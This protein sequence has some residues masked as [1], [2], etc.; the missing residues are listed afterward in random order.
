MDVNTLIPLISGALAAAGA[1]YLH[2]QRTNTERSQL[3]SEQY[4][5]ASKMVEQYVDDL[6]ELSERVGKLQLGL[7]QANEEL[8]TL[9]AENSRLQALTEQLKL[10]NSLLRAEV[11]K[12]GGGA[13]G[14]GKTDGHG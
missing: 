14:G 2:S 12:L 10:E 6:H 1:I 13:G 5:S 3:A 7:L 11:D 9:K 8:A 4:A